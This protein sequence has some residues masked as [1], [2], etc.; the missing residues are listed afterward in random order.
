[1]N[2]RKILLVIV[3][4]VSLTS[5]GFTG[6]AT[7]K[8]DLKTTLKQPSLTA[9]TE[10]LT[11]TVTPQTK[12]QERPGD[13]P[14]VATP[15]PVVD[16]ML[17][18]AKVGKNDMLY[19]LGSGDGRIVITA[20]KNYGTRG[21]GIDIS[22]DRIKEA[23]ENAQKVGVSDHVRFIQQDLF[24]TD[25]SEATVVTLYLLPEVNLKLRPRLFQQLKPGTRI[26]SHAF[27]M[28]D[29]KPQQTL[30]VNG[31]TIYYWVIPENL[32]ANLR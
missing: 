4:G 22:P 1:M 32:P 5:W 14:Y 16:A 30:K 10:T 19:D 21:V 12:P 27:D 31:K 15:Q 25:L 29:W 6:S 20:A 24:N 3:A 28:G 18:V 17:K 26:V 8:L 9:Q 7:Q 2:L 23:N 11:P 13:V